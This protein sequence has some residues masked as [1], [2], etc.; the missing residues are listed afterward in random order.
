M[1][2]YA[3]QSTCMLH[4]PSVALGACTNPPIPPQTIP[5]KIKC[6]IPIHATPFP[7]PIMPWCH[8]S[9]QSLLSLARNADSTPSSVRA[10]PVARIPDSQIPMSQCTRSQCLPSCYAAQ[11]G[12]WSQSEETAQCLPR[13]R[14]RIYHS[15]HSPL[16]SCKSM[17]LVL[18]EHPEH[19][20][21]MIHAS[22]LQSSCTWLRIGSTP[23]VAATCRQRQRSHS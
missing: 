4:L 14:P 15:H 2:L 17:L 11:R 19:P 6:Q 21:G 20:R 8:L 7:P 13:A 16:T 22:L 5:P 12:P 1:P 10:G 3:R 9:K 18:P 23:V